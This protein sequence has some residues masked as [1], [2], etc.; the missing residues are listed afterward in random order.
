MSDK[1]MDSFINNLFPFVLSFFLLI[2]VNLMTILFLLKIILIET[3]NQVLT[4]LYVFNFF[5]SALIILS[6]I[7]TFMVLAL[8]KIKWLKNFPVGETI[9]IYKTLL[10]ILTLFCSVYLNMLKVTVIEYTSEINSSIQSVTTWTLTFGIVAFSLNIVYLVV[11][12][13]VP[14]FKKIH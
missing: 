4:S 13:I 5:I 12:K 8:F 10:T 6:I 9:D 2:L 1:S 14:L 7:I 3:N 11:Y